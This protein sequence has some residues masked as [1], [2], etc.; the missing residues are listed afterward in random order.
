MDCQRILE[1]TKSHEGRRCTK[2]AQGKTQI[3]Q[4]GA[5]FGVLAHAGLPAC[6]E[7]TKRIES[8]FYNSINKG[9]GRL[10][11]SPEDGKQAAERLAS[12]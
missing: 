5:D 12:G 8:F 2:D 1:N 3:S 9:A 11:K 7:G 10:N 6:L 4:I